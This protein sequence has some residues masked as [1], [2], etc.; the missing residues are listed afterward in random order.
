MKINNYN[1]IISKTSPSEK[2]KGQNT[3]SFSSAQINLYPVKNVNPIKKILP[4]LAFT[5]ATI[6]AL[7]YLLGG[8]GLYYDLFV[9]KK[10]NKNNNKQQNINDEGVKTIQPTTTIG[11][12]GMNCGKVAVAANAISGIACGL[13]EGIPL[14]ALGESMGLC[15]SSIIETPVGTALFGMGIGS[16]FAGLALDN[17]PNL[18]L[19]HY[20]LMAKKN[21]LQKT[22]LILS[23]MG[24]T[25]LEIS[26]SIFQIGK[27]IFN[28]TWMKDNIFRITPKTIVFSESIN[29]EGK[30][31]VSKMLRHNK[32]YL[33]HAASFTLAL[34]GLGIIISTIFKQKKAQKKGLQAEETGF[35]FDNFGMTK[36][37]IDKFTTG[38]KSAGA[39]FAIGGI[40][41]AI[42][43]FIGLD[44]K[45]GRALQWLG[46]S[47]VFLGFSIDRGKHLRQA[48]KDA[49][50]QPELTQI[51]RE[52][53]LDLS[54][55][56]TDK[57]ELKKLLKELKNGST[58]NETFLG[59]EKALTEATTALKGKDKDGNIIS[60]YN[61]NNKTIKQALSKYFKQHNITTEFELSDKHFM[62]LDDAIDTLQ[63]CTKKIFGTSNPVPIKSNN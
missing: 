32:N 5:C 12:L 13:G 41:N 46:I 49:K 25:A 22:S 59:I 56:I 10:N 54:K 55:I 9:D 62:K 24:K 14:M 43:Q 27:N 38:G 21:I 20:E 33:M 45:N 7:G 42:S 44:N 52:W 19:N 50:F 11:K 2:I 39:S 61:S 58:T 40:I 3:T 37:G 34:G 16:I 53:K 47:G 35:L 15:S 48:L 36:Y 23:N 30:V 28:P 31:I 1:P 6:G 8:T 60:L 4:T 63:T 18:K 57:A 26:K 29:K 51:L 17:T